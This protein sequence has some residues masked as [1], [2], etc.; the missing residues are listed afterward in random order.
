MSRPKQDGL[1]YFS[2]DTDF[3][4]ADKRIKR[5]HSRYGNDGLIFYIYLL[6]E[7]YRNG[8]FARWD[9]DII[10]DAIGLGLTEGLIEQIMTFLVGRSLLVKST[11]ANSDTIITSPGIQRRYQEAAKSLKRDVFVNKEIWL[12][13]EEET[14][15]YIK[16][17][18]NDNKSEKNDNKSEKNDSKSG[19]ND[20]KETKRKEI[21]RNNNTCVSRFQ[22]F[23]TVYPKQKNIIAAE[24]EYCLLLFNEQSLTEQELII[25]AKNYADAVSIL[26]TEERYIKNPDRFLKD[27]TYLDYL[28]VNYTK[29][30]AEKQKRNA[31][32]GM[33]RT[34]YGDLSEL[35]KELLGN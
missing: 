35:E 14:A 11:L 13:G 19:K 17:T 18:I 23:F 3:F 5:L 8:Y 20:T 31:N 7:I 10:D 22:D 29:P 15:P 30:S 9:E 33:M 32:S 12:V 34:D 16:F 27:G 2:F 4:Y 24:K 28:D 25:S 21:K 6:T 1:K 26:R